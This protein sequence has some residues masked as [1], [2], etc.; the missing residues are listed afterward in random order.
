MPLFSIVIPAYNTEKYLPACLDSLKAQSF[1]DWEAVVVVDASPDDCAG[2]VKRCVR[3]DG[4]FR[5]IEK[6]VNGGV[7]A[8][9]RDGA[10]SGQ[11]DYLIFLDSDDA[12][13]PGALEALS[14]ALPQDDKVILHFGT[15][16]MADG[17]SAERAGSF[18][19]WANS[20]AGP[21]DRDELLK[22]VFSP[23][24]EYGKDW[25]ITH[26]LVSAALAKDA[27]SRMSDERLTL[28]ED[29]YEVF[30]LALL[31]HGEVTHDDIEAYRY[32]LGRG[33]TN[34]ATLS[35]EKYA[36]ETADLM[37]SADAA[38]EFARS[39][40]YA[41]GLIVAEHLRHR[42]VF[43][44]ANE[45]TDH[46]SVGQ[47]AEGARVLADITGACAAPELMRLARDR[48]Y[49]LLDGGKELTDNDPLLEWYETAKKLV[50]NDFASSSRFMGYYDAAKS[51]INDLRRCT[52]LKSYENQDVRIFISA[53]KPVD[54]FDSSI[55]QPVQVGC[56]LRG[57]RFNW[58]FYDDE[59]NNI[60]DQNA[61]YCELT[62]Q[63][64]AWKNTQSDYVGFCHYRRYFDFNPERHAENEYGEIMDSFIDASSQAE[65][66]LDDASISAFVK[67]Y[68]VVTTER[69]DICAYLGKGATL[70]SQ[71]DAA[72]KLYVED[73]DKIVAILKKQHPEYGQDA[74]AFLAGH[75]GRFC[76]MFIMKRE[77]FNDYCAWLFPLL[78]EFVAT[79]DMSLYSVEGVRTPGHLAERL[80]N[81]YLLHHERVNTGWKMAEVQCVHFTNPDYH[82]ELPLLS[83]GEDKRPLIPVVFASDNN[84]V[85]MLTT[86]I[87]S[88]LRNASTEYHYDV[89]VLHKDIFGDNQAQMR[90]FLAQFDNATLRFCDVSQ[91]IDQY[92]LT[93]NNPH[94][95][96]E[97]YYRFLIQ[98][99]LPYYNKVLY[100]DSDLI[101]KGDIAELY[102]TELG[103][104]LLAAAHDIDFLG[105]LNVKDGKRMKYAKTVLK[106]DNPYDYF[107]A[108]VLVLNTRAMRE[109][110][111]METWLEYA[112]N[113]AYIYNDQDVLNVC[114]EGR[115]TWLDYDWNVMIDCNGRIANVFSFAPAAS[116][117]AF[118]DSR[119]HERIVH[120]AGF[121][122]P[123]KFPTCDRSALYW[124]YA[125]KTPY[126]EKLLSMLGG[127]GGGSSNSALLLHE[128]AINIDSP[129]RRFIDPIM[130][131]GSARRE[132]IKSIARTVRRRS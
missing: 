20:T 73:L 91:I 62:T 84:Y 3:E 102:N 2:I 110:H 118:N 111:P 60:S 98:K 26:R 107:Q 75:I 120:Y 63:Y 27:F 128:R 4:R 49:E 10:L 30:C 85:P 50:G 28:A 66:C 88:A 40:G 82:D 115:V 71:Y 99:L 7:H 96:V 124:E 81:I 51:H 104:N 12:L 18:E 16:C 8:A 21:L 33:I 59:G 37:K 61:M 132:M 9:R 77:I 5:L 70:R 43:A 131:V 121:E 123:W 93:T 83:G 44:A 125:R 105:N 129:V 34:D 78:E 76:N 97:T 113:D 116:F 119:N 130:P 38:D 87:Y 1:D 31:S 92:E 58:S 100:L 112:S 68:D 39:L 90:S 46:V 72:D 41:E 15:R 42:L 13:T 6:E 69:K 64:W 35:L 22:A 45:L 52:R 109:L 53:H 48:A 14:Q 122:K 103:D 55:L 127:M 114:C 19:Q 56:A 108:G 79:T 67:Q 24:A 32:N 11:G 74:D 89:V 126:Y 57:D 25:N 94:I 117:K 54:L 101:V 47:R 17:V 80:L 95:S 86:T 29:A 36:S 23:D 65:Y 106:M